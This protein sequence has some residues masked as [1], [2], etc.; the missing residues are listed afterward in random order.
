MRKIIGLLTAGLLA[1]GLI[2]TPASAG[3]A[4]FAS[5]KFT[6]KANFKAAKG[7]TVLLV[8]RTGRVLASAKITKTTQP[9]TLV[10]PVVSS[11]QGATLQLVTTSGGDYYGPVVLG[12][13]SK[14]SVYTQ[15]NPGTAK[16]L[17]F[18]VINNKSVTSKQ[19]YGLATAKSTKVIKTK[20]VSATNY[21]PKGVGNYGKSGVSPMSAKSISV[22]AG[23]D[24]TDS[25]AGA[26]ADGDGLTNAFDVNDDGDATV[27][28]ADSSTPT[29]PANPQPN[30]VACETAASFFIFTNFKATA[31]EF[32]EN[33]NAYGRTGSSF[34]ATPEKIASAISN[35]MSMVISPIQNVCGSPVV[36]T[37]LKGVGVPYA[38][39]DFVD[40]GNPGNTGDF[41]WTI[42][43]GKISNVEIAGLPTNRSGNE[44]GWNF[45]SPSE[46][47]GQDTFIQRVT[48]QAG[49]TYEFTSTAGFIFVT[50]PLPTRYRVDNGQGF[51]DWQNFFNDQG[52]VVFGNQQ[53]I[54]LYS[55]TV[56]EI[57]MF[58][59]QRLAIDG[60][61]GT[62]YDLAGMRYTPDI[63]NGP[64]VEGQ[65]PSQGAGKCDVETHLDTE[66]LADTAINTDTKP[67]LTISW[68]IG[69]CYSTK[70]PAM[71]WPN[72][73]VSVDIQVEPQGR[74]GNS[75]QK[76]QFLLIPPA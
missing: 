56:M 46:I 69:R 18:G 20:A 66:M 16:T 25:F 76:I 52:Q 41:Q 51:G 22:Y 74:G 53:R 15:M 64:M 48:T 40:I 30:D 54:E 24:A 26:D 9:V 58:R 44:K 75:A 27:D 12:W 43:N 47:S 71:N 4:P 62:F 29:P 55:Q 59:P 19:G 36:K 70:N 61:T 11:I 60:E 1:I 13:A 42:G 34:E 49:K 6:V 50:H 23:E 8:A 31:P 14:T 68:E 17:N 67:R 39:T 7:K 45:T 65:P 33:I 72:G 10:T 2:S 35:T 3:V 73:Q 57:E 28:L 32:Q 21:K 63:P 5:A 37:E 38:P